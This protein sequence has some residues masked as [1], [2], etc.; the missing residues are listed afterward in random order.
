MD[1][2][3]TETEQNLSPYLQK[4]DTVFFTQPSHGEIVKAIRLHLECDA[5]LAWSEKHP[6]ATIVGIEDPLLHRYH[7][8]L[9]ELSQG[10]YPTT[11]EWAKMDGLLHLRISEMRSIVALSKIV[12]RMKKENKIKGVIVIGE[13]H[14]VG[15][16]LNS[17]ELGLSSRFFT[18][19]PK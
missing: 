11:P 16:R 19:V 2:V 15:M 5:V 14:A 4:L 17:T 13:S 8:A 18:T 1:S 9:I 10:K 7:A 12:S 3:V 6:E